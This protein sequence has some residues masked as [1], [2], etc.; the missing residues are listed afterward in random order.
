MPGNSV[1]HQHYTIALRKRTCETIPHENASRMATMRVRKCLLL[2]VLS[3]VAFGAEPPPDGD[4]WMAHFVRDLLPFWDM[5]AAL[6]SP[7]GVFPSTRC[8]NGSAIDYSKP[9][10]EVNNAYLLTRS[11]YLVPLS[12][13]IYGYG[14]AF[15]LT[16]DPKY[17]RYMKAGIDVLRTS[18]IDRDAGGIFEEQNLDTG[19]MGP[20]VE[21]RDPQQLG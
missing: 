11:R 14:V 15:H 18:W 6:G 17:L 1:R 5:P 2:A 21:L 19:A 13:Q 7:I 9:C 3:A 8:N 16:G 20:A 12:R 4:W 10:P